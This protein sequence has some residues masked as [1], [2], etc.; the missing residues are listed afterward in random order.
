M[1]WGII[2]FIIAPSIDIYEWK[3]TSIKIREW[4]ANKMDRSGFNEMIL[5]MC[6]CVDV[7]STSS[8][9]CMRVMCIGCSRFKRNLISLFR[10]AEGF[11]F[12]LLPHYLLLFWILLK[13]SMWNRLIQFFDGIFNHFREVGARKMNAMQKKNKEEFLRKWMAIYHKKGAQLCLHTKYIHVCVCM[14]LYIQI[15]TVKPRFATL[16]MPNKGNR[17]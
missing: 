16:A 9:T 12:L 4:F 1:Y 11:F 17:C 14:G 6:V 2:Y 15:E 8:I 10:Y 3:I 5:S 13:L 7:R